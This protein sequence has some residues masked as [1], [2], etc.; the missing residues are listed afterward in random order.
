[1]PSEEYTL[2]DLDG[3]RLLAAVVRAAA[4]G[5]EVVRCAVALR[6]TDVPGDSAQA[7]GVWAGAQ[8]KAAGMSRRALVI[9]AR[10]AR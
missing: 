1:M 8:L 6:P 2:I 4:G 7:V 3:Q 9:A 10:A 5:A